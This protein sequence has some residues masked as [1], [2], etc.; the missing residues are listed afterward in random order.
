VLRK[1]IRRSQSGSPIHSAIR[2]LVWFITF[3]SWPLA[4]SSSIK[5]GDKVLH[6]RVVRRLADCSFISP[7]QFSPSELGTQEH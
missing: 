4:N 1:T 6:R 3:L 2:P 5:L 7:T